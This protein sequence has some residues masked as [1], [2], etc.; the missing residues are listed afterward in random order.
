MCRPAAVSGGRAFA[1]RAGPA[2]SQTHSAEAE[3]SVDVSRTFLTFRP[4]RRVLSHRDLEAI[5][6]RLRR[7]R[8][9]DQRVPAAARMRLWNVAVHNMHLLLAAFVRIFPVRAMTFVSR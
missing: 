7:S 6:H 8:R 9:R 2:G 5:R 1:S 3:V 4:G